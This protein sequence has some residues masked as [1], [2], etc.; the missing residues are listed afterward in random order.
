M[1]HVHLTLL[2]YMSI[3][4]ISI[5]PSGLGP[6]NVHRIGLLLEIWDRLPGLCPGWELGNILINGEQICL[7]LE[8][9][10]IH[11]AGLHQRKLGVQRIAK[12]LHASA[13]SFSHP[14]LTSAAMKVIK[15]CT[16][17]LLPCIQVHTHQHCVQVRFPAGSAALNPDADIPRRNQCTGT[18]WTCESQ[19]RKCTADLF[20][21]RLEELGLQKAKALHHNS[22]KRHYQHGI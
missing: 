10:I 2:T 1:T 11:R 18:F 19:E 16:Q 22:S 6:H 4:G 12:H 9:I 7:E 14:A 20:Q 21:Y 15:P 5:L 8:Q 17:G 13:T 3:T